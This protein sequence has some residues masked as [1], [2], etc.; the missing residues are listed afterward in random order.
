M[1]FC[2]FALGIRIIVHRLYRFVILVHRLR[3]SVQF[4]LF[5]LLSRVWLCDPMDC[6]TSD[7]SVQHWLPEF[8]QA[9]VHCVGDAIQPSHPL[10]S[11]LLLLSIFPSIR[12]FSTESVLHIRWPKYQSFSFSISLSN[13]YLEWFPLEWTGWISMLS[14]GFSRVFNTTV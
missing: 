2:T 12:V 6:S 14:K 7:P 10:S 5:Q 8:T 3:F 9:H 11:L 4:S 13:E 1:P